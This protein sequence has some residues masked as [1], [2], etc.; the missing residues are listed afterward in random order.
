M[1]KSIICFLAVCLVLLIGCNKKE[2]QSDGIIEN[3][4]FEN[5]LNYWNV[6][7]NGITVFGNDNKYLLISNN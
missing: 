6:K 4:G 2:H 7:S 1:K 5:S 3:S